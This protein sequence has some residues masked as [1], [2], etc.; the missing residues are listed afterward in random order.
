MSS[1]AAAEAASGSGTAPL[2]KISV[3]IPAYQ[4]QRYLQATIDSLLSQDCRDLEI[5][6]I[7][8]NSSDG[9]CEIL[10]AITDERVRV[11]RNGST[12][13]LVENWNLAV[14][15]CQ[16]E[17]V[18]LICADDILDSNCIAAQRKVLEDNLSVALVAVQSD[19][20]DDDG[21]LL[22]RARGLAGIV[23]RQSAHRVVKRIVRSGSNPIGAPVTTMFRRAD[24][25]RSGGFRPDF[26]FAMD[27][28]LWV[29]LLGY[30]DF[31][32]MDRNLAA[33]RVTG[34]SV[35][36]SISTRSQL[37]EQA[38]FSRRLVDDPRWEITAVDEAIGKVNR[39][40]MQMRRTAMYFV[41]TM[42]AR[43]TA[44]SETNRDLITSGEER[45]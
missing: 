11:I 34:S 32:G 22:R 29:R 5:V 42:R 4:A 18:K 7:D 15:R 37:A 14:A 12:L 9:T 27:L 6:V 21:R 8:N 2:P 26:R 36:A 44:H 30:G 20:I 13:P 40:V 41:R 33:F 38:E 17:F 10:D 24:F 35:T 31:F 39:Y 45:R 16:G 3:C 23:G 1:R 19:Y 25:D 43:R 28:D